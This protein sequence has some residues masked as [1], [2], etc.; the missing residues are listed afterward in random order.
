M[1]S[2][3]KARLSA[4]VSDEELEYYGDLFVRCAIRGAGV[5][6]ETFLTN[7][8][9]YLQ[10]HAKGHPALAGRDGGGRKGLRDYLRLRQTTRA[11]SG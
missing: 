9:Y 5:D 3:Q 4:R 6:F 2:P 7:P 1:G 10:K 11:S 8:E